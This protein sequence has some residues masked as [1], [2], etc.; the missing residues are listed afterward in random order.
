MKTQKIFIYQKREMILF[1]ALLFLSF[2]F[3]FILGIHLA[4]NIGSGTRRIASGSSN[5]LESE[6]ESDI[7][8]EEL[9]DPGKDAPKL[10]EDSLNHELHEEVS[11]T[12]I[13][14]RPSRAI[15]LPEKTKSRNAGATRL[16]PE[17]KKAA[18][19]HGH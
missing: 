7:N 13:K 15:E 14:L 3:V 8:R 19:P 5:S 4:K 16:E 11:R 18:H 9:S 10:I 12:G 1:S 6:D 17:V 2:S